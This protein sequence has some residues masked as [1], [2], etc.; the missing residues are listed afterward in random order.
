MRLKP[1]KPRYMPFFSSLKMMH[2]L[3]CI[4]LFLRIDF[5][6]EF[7][8][9]RLSCS[10]TLAFFLPCCVRS[11]QKNM[12]WVGTLVPILLGGSVEVWEAV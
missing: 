5:A 11:S 12:L 4:I 10:T 8:Y 6:K 7:V 1:V 3:Y 2:F 9:V